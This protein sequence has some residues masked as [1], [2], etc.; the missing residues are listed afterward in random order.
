MGSTPEHNFAPINKHK[1]KSE[2]TVREVLRAAEIVFIRDGFERAQ[3]ESIASE[4]RRTKGAVYTHFATKEAIFFAVVE[5]KAQGRLDTYIRSTQG[6]PFSRVVEEGK[7]LFLE[8]M[9]EKNWA[10]LLLEFKL[11]ALRNEASLE[12]IRKLYDLIYHD[13]ERDL[14]SDELN[15]TATQKRRALIALALLRSMPSAVALESQFNQ[16]MNRPKD[17]TFVLERLYDAMV[18]VNHP[19]TRES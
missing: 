17:V 6:I 7:R 2:A 19:G 13:A 10:I 1:A 3:I 5:T 8:T 15:F 11:F 9:E 14:L 4:A 18:G 16:V 12:R